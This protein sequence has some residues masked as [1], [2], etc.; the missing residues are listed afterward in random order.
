MRYITRFTQCFFVLILISCGESTD[1]SQFTLDTNASTPNTNPEVSVLEGQALDYTVDLSGY[2]NAYVKTI[3]E[4]PDW[5]EIATPPLAFKGTPPR[6]LAGEYTVEFVVNNRDDGEL[7]A[8]QLTITVEP[9]LMLS[10][11]VLGGSIE[12]ALVYIDENNNFEFDNSDAD[13]TEPHTFTDAEGNYNLSVSLSYQPA[14]GLFLIRS[15]LDETVINNAASIVDYTANP[16]TLSATP[17][18]IDQIVDDHMENIGISAF[19]DHAYN[20]VEKNIQQ[21]INGSMESEDLKNKISNAKKTVANTFINDPRLDRKNITLTDLEIQN[22]VFSDYS[23]SAP[24]LSFLAE[25]SSEL[26]NRIIDQEP[27]AD[28]DIDG[29]PNNE[30]GDDDGDGINDLQDVFPFNI[31][32]WLDSDNDGY[33]D[34]SDYYPLDSKC[35]LREDGDDTSCAA[36]ITSF[37]NQ[38]LPATWTL[39]SYADNSWSYSTDDSANGFFHLKGSGSGLKL[40]IT[41]TFLEPVKLRFDGKGSRLLLIDIDGVDQWNRESPNINLSGDWS[42]YELVIPAGEHVINLAF[43]TAY[44]SSSHVLLDNFRLISVGNNFS[45]GYEYVLNIEEELY[46][47]DVNN[48]LIRNVTIQYGLDELPSYPKSNI[49]VLDDG[50][51][52]IYTRISLTPL[53]SIYSPSTNTWQHHSDTTWLSEASAATKGLVGKD[54][55]I[56]LSHNTG[57]D[58]IGSGLYRYNL[59]NME[60]DVFVYDVSYKNL[61]LGLDGFLYGFSTQEK[62]L[63][64]I[65]PDTM[66]IVSEITFEETISGVASGSKFAVDSQGNIYDALNPQ[67]IY[68]YDPAGNKVETIVLSELYKT[69]QPAFGALSSSNLG[70]INTYGGI[71]INRQNELYLMSGCC[72]KKDVWKTD[73]EFESIDFLIQSDDS[74]TKLALPPSID[75]D[76]DSVP[77]W[78]ETKYGFSDDNS[79]DVTVDTDND[80]ISNLNEFIARADPTRVDTDADGLSD[81]DEI[82]IYQSSPHYK[83]S[84]GDFILDGNEVNFYKTNPIQIDSDGDYVNDNEEVYFYYTDP[85]SVDSYPAKFTFDFDDGVIPTSWSNTENKE[86]YAFQGRLYAGRSDDDSSVIFSSLFNEG[87]LKFDVGF[88]SEGIDSGFLTVLSSTDTSDFK[89]IK[90]ISKNGHYEVPIEA[91]TKHIKFTHIEDIPNFQVWIDNVSFEPLQ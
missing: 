60:G 31:S 80:G 26:L 89:D 59:N 49:T 3:Y 90:T 14:V 7:I 70:Y 66:T 24:E 73:T 63:H 84:D 40:T 77:K 29:I 41:D 56:Y 2:N 52:A 16:I 32:E 8:H 1:S 57:S 44:S 76:N 54:N 15:R 19:S 34:N 45:M 51:I 53:L 11:Q 69:F 43:G 37:E 83:D 72:V 55:F 64:K 18:Y 33:G 46:F 12:N 87:V 88:T 28:F 75:N 86:W 20:I 79:H 82:N 78:W 74:N 67:F 47:Y 13:N 25:K 10:G 38:E 58:F 22:T 68:K 65:N 61:T 6:G 9:S 48:E 85:T 5:L 62:L 17:F 30:D 50:N 23:N 35:N 21:E 4:M 81:F 71:S 91:G 42:T 27:N 36:L 39:S